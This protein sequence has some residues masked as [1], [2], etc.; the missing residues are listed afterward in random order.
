M[1]V[2]PV[3]LV[4]D[5]DMTS[6]TITEQELRKRY[7][8]DY[9]VL[10]RQSAAAA[11]DELRRLKVE[12]QPVALILAD[13]VMPEMSGPDFLGEAR[14]IDPVAKRVMLVSWGD[15]SAPQAI[16]T[17]CAVGQIEFFITK[18]WHTAT[19]E[20]FHSEVAGFLY[21]WARL[22]RPVY[23]AVRIVGERWAPRSHELRDLLGRNGVAYGFYDADSEEGREIL[24][25]A[26]LDEAPKLPVVV[27]FGGRVLVDPSN[28]EVVGVARGAQ[29]AVRRRVRPARRR[30]G[31]GRP[32][33]RRL[34]LFRG[35]QHGGARARGARWAGRPEHHDPQ[36]PRLPRRHL[37]RRADVPRLRAGVAVRGRVPVL[38]RGRLAAPRRRRAPRRARGRRVAPRRR[39]H[40][41]HGRHA[42]G[43]WRCRAWIRSVARVCSTGRSRPRRDRWSTWTCTSSAAATPPARP[44]ST[45]PS[46]LVT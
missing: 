12:G 33:R 44:P 32:R 28:R 14:V 31:A 26:G 3:I 22:Q 38:Q 24:R 7:G 40:P 15:R 1:S 10:A 43:A 46:T 30:R 20:R 42:T 9:R 29:P 5:D 16:L 4:V 21:E 19:D 34:R 39:R 41:R 36:L 13:Q 45:S 27:V 2:Q 6:L 17:G 35:P 25:D 18:P 11:L 8:R 23:E 37:R